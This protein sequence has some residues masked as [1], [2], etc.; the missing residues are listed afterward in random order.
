MASTKILPK[1]NYKIGPINYENSAND[2]ENFY[3]GFVNVSKPTT[4]GFLY[5]LNYCVSKEG[6]K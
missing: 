6:F 5:V 4:F 2:E 1:I 3:K